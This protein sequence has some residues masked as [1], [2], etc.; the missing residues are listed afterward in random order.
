MN[1]PL[2]VLFFIDR[3]R[4]GGIQALAKD[5]LIHND[6]SRMVID[7]LN[8]DDGIEYPLRE[9]LVDM[10][11][12][13]YQLKDTWLRTPLDF[14]T[15]WQVVDKFFEQHHDYDVVHVHSGPKNYYIL[16]AAKRWSVPVRVAHSHNTGFQSKNLM[17]ILL[18]NVLKGPMT[19]N[20][21]HCVGCSKVACEWLFGKGSVE[22]GK[23]KVILNTIDSKLFVY[24]ENIRK[25]V[26][27]ELAL[28]DKFVIGHVG[29]LEHQK[30]HDFLIDI[31]AEIAKKKTNAYLVLVGIGSLQQ[32]L[33][34]KAASLGL[35]DQIKFLGFR[36]DRYRIMQA[37]DSFVFP[38]FHE[39]LSVVLIEAQASGLPVFVSDSTTTEVSFSPDIKFLSL[40][41]SAKEWAEAVLEKDQVIRRDMAV[42]IK[43]AGF[44]IHTMIDNLYRMYVRE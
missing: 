26:R 39:G 18:G 11:I 17:S 35:I 33:E 15:Y 27:R 44:E 10:G 8:L 3:L 30:N 25:E 31:F 43:K 34:Q 32:A 22:S 28:E 12:T 20:A 24:N 36:D 19:R 1:K 38:S 9:T 16:K 37:M 7:V 23:A 2:K 21:T 14:F 13:I 4:L 42:D 40:K 29:R 6:R 41:Q 5:I